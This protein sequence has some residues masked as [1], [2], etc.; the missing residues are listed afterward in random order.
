MKQTLVILSNHTKIS[1]KHQRIYLETYKSSQAVPLTLINGI[2][3]YGKA[4]ITSDALSACA[5]HNVP[6][7][8]VSKYG[9]IK[10]V[11]M[12]NFLSSANNKRI[13]QYHIYINSRLEVAKEIVLR[14]L[15]EIEYYF[16]LDFRDIEPVLKRTSNY[17]VILGCE[18]RASK[19]MFEKF[20]ELVNSAGWKFS[21]RSYRPPRD[22]VNALLSSAYTLGY[23]LAMVLICIF[24]L[25][26]YLSFLHIKRGR[27][28]SFASDLM[29]LIRPKLTYLIARLIKEG[30]INKS[31]FV[32]DKNAYFLSKNGYS[33]VLSIYEEYKEE[34]ISI[35]K[36]F[37]LNLE[38]FYKDNKSQGKINVDSAL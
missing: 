6:V 16:S 28:A 2:I 34:M 24:G 20:G 37:V 35:M 19:E 8:F 3:I 13:L 17:S 22:K 18:G 15:K 7:C 11:F 26:P 23:S 31:D 36:D 12:P 29:E 25:D 5:K 14:K 33:A 38:K 4:T 9:K 27:H 32:K 21:G 1:R 10:G 30:K